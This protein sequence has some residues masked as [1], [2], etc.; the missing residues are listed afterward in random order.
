VAKLLLAHKADLN[1]RNK[2]GDTPLHLAAL[3]DQL[4]VATLLLAGKA[5]V[6]SRNNDGATPMNVAAKSGYNDMADLLHR[7]GGH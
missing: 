3:A 1:A 7:S 4:D 2:D 5:S 6:N